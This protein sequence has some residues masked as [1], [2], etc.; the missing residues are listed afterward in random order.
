[1]D[2]KSL[3]PFPGNR[4]PAR[5]AEDSHPLPMLRREI[6]QLFDDFFRG[7]GF[8][9]LADRMPAAMMAPRLDVSE[10]ENEIQIAAE[11]PGIDEKDVEVTLVD[12]LL[13][14]RGE[15][16]AERKQDERN[17]HLMERSEGM[18]VR[19]LRLPFTAEAKEIK[20]SFKD[21]VLTITIP[22]PKEVREKVQKI[23]VARDESGDAQQVG[24]NQPQTA[25][26][27]EQSAAQPQQAAAE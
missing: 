3:M 9:V 11:L 18:F 19:S 8:P 6:D 24:T 2:A 20:A 12:D 10:T 16:K 1:M 21:G 14:I 15:K 17:Y 4:T 13:T 26:Q 5:R 27:P 22:K 23:T 7:F 25:A